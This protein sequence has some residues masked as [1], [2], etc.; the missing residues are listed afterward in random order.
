MEPQT[1][2]GNPAAAYAARLAQRRRQRN[3]RR[4]CALAAFLALGLSLGTIWASGFATTGSTTGT[5]ST[6]P[7]IYA[8][9]GNK[10]DTSGLNGL[11]SSGG[12]LTWNWQG[13]WGS[14]S[15]KAMYTA[16][17]DTLSAGG[18]YYVGVYL[19]NVPT[20]FSDLQ[21][22]LRIA[23]VGTGGTCNAAAIE[24]VG[25]TSDY[26]IFTFDAVDAQVTFSGMG[27]ATGLPGG[28]TYCVG[29]DNYSGSG[30]DPAGTYIRKSSSGP[31]FS[32]IHPTFV[33]ALNQ[34]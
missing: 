17:L 29:I 30:Q 5:A 14:V 19:T 34:M 13:Q 25:T 24:A 23:D 22:Q 32:G 6:S 8:N 18:K 9:P 21:L 2:I 7:F 3:R 26:R 28:K 27:G 16:D 10:Q 15:S 12:D 1:P 11:L 31:S 4:L 33:A 20:G